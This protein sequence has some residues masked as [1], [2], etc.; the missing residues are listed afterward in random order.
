MGGRKA[1][2]EKAMI[3]LKKDE[4]IAAAEYRRAGYSCDSGQMVLGRLCGL[5]S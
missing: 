4:W 1:G 5:P 2:G 3:R